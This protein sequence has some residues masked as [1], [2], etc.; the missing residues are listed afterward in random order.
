MNQKQSRQHAK[1]EL[2]DVITHPLEAFIKAEASGGIV[3]MVCTIIALIIANTVIAHQWEALW[4]TPIALNWGSFSLDHHLNHWI[5]DG[6]MVIFFFS[7]GLEIKREFLVGEL[8]SLRKAAFP[9]F[10]AM[11]GMIV[12]ASIFLLFN[13]NTQGS[14][15][16]GIPMATDIAFALGIILLLGKR[17]PLSIKIFLT[18]LAIVDDLGAVMVIALFY[19]SQIDVMSLLF[20]AGIV[21]ILLMANISGIRHPFI[22]G[23]LGIVL[24]LAFMRSG[25]HTTIAGVILAFTVPAR[26]RMD[27][28][29]FIHRMEFLLG[30]MKKECSNNGEECKVLTNQNQQEL[31]DNMEADLHHAESPMQRMEHDLRPWVAFFI[32]PLFALANAGVAFKGD[33]LASITHPVA[34]GIIAGL[35]IGKPLGITLFSW[36]AVKS[37]FAE[38]PPE[39]SWNQIFAVS[40]LGGIGFT[41]SIFINNLAFTNAAI[42]NQAKTGILI[43][44][45]IA[46]LLGVTALLRSTRRKSS[47]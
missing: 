30:H 11:G 13:H 4:H 42:Q 5:N 47:V 20:A 21:F 1:S 14:A 23:L 37:G 31:M 15:G 10:A 44:S 26:T 25:I 45:F 17:V 33:F 40:I 6:L 16:W 39:T 27:V 28:P 9:I 19:T 8:R 35:V 7:V 36:I 2:I 32:I 3:L 46:I 29:Q 34:L 18:A 38:K 24:W 43:A 12:P 41:M 22:Y